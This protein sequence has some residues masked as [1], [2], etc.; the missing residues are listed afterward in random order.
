[1]DPIYALIPIA[2]IF[3]YAFGYHTGLNVGK[4]NGFKGIAAY[5]QKEWP[6]EARAYRKGISEGYDQGLRDGHADE[7]S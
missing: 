5:V 4:H 3:A 6:N 2:S 1:M 7:P